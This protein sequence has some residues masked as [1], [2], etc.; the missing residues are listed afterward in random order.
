VGIPA[1]SLPHIFERFYRIDPSRANEEG[2]GLG[3]AI[4]K[5]IV[6]IHHATISVESLEN[7]GTTFSVRFRLV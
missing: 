2:T 6:D 3:L 4:A 5:W 1:S 7:Q